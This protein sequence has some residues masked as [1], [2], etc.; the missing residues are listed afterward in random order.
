MTKRMLIPVFVLLVTILVALGIYLNF[1]TH[2][3]DRPSVELSVEQTACRDSTAAC[4]LQHPELG[5]V[6]LTFAEGAYYLHPFVARLVTPAAGGAI[7]AVTLDLTMPGMDMG[8]NVFSLHPQAD[9]SGWQG[10]VLLPICVTGR[11]DWQ[12]RLVIETG[13]R[14][15]VARLPLQVK[16]YPA[17]Q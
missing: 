12:V 4:R 17:S 15:Y 8:R 10:T 13:Q 1:V 5:V 2:T 11:I 9:G 16:R 6:Q 3:T 7:E 14:H